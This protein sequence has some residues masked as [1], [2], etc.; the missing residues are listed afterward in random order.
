MTSPGASERQIR[1][2]RPLVRP[3]SDLQPAS[4]IWYTPMRMPL[5]DL[6]DAYAMG[7]MPSGDSF[8][9]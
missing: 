6:S 8:R 7:C 1:S 9:R 3:Y 5:F 2:L 4:S